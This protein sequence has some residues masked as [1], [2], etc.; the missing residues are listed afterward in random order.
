MYM[1]NCLQFSYSDVMV[2][3][4]ATF[5]PVIYTRVQT[6]DGRHCLNRLEDAKNLKA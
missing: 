2:W 3:L 5:E 4:Y 6:S 1:L